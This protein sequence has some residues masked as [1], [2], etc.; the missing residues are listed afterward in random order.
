MR[1]GEWGSRYKLPGAGLSGMGYPAPLYVVYVFVFLVSIIISRLYKLTPFIRSPSRSPTDS[2]SDISVKI[3]SRSTLA[4]GG[5]EGD[6]KT[7]Y[8][9]SN[10]LSAATS[11]GHSSNSSSILE[12]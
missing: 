3:F 6:R 10:P 7:F 8:Q 11:S 4:G 9:G 1:R 12:Q 2:L 5:A